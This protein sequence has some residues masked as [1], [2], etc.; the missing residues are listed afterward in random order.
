MGARKRDIWEVWK[1]TGQLESVKVFIKDCSRKLITQREMC[2]YLN[3]DEATFCRLKKKYP[4]ISELQESAKLDLKKDLMDALYKK[5]VGYETVEEDQYIEDKGSGRE[6][7]RKI[8]RIKKQ[9]GPDYKA[10]VYLLTKHFG[11]EYIERYDEF[12]VVSKLKQAQEEE[13]NKN[14]NDEDEEDENV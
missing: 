1:D 12:L 2:K 4:E 3:I 6:Q 14:T 7:K 11:H 10:I 8:H 13:W 9:V 5:A